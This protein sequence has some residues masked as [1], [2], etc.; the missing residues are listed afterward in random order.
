MTINRVTVFSITLGFFITLVANLASYGQENDLTKEVQVVKPYEPSISDAFKINQMPQ[1]EDTIKL[2][3]SFTYN[4]ALRPVRTEFPVKPIPAARMVA[5]PLNKVYRSYIKFGYGN[6]NS[7]LAEFYLS[8]VRS[9]N[10]SYG[11]AV[12]HHSSFGDIKIDNND[13]V[14]GGFAKTSIMAFGKRMFEKSVLSASGGFRYYSYNFYGVDTMAIPI[15]PQIGFNPDEQY[16]RS[17]FVDISYH[18]THSDST[19]I[20][21]KFNGG[22]KAFADNYGMEQNTFS[23]KAEIDKFFKTE[24]VGG[25]VEFTHHMKNSTLDSANNTIFRF[26]P[27]MGLFGK[28]W[29]V[30]IGVNFAYDANSSGNQSHFFPTGTMSYDIVSH[31]VIPYIEFSGYLEDNNYAKLLSE[32]PWIEPGLDVW[33]TRHK[34]IMMGGV[35]GNFNPRIAYNVNASFS[36]VDSMYFYVNPSSTGT[37][38]ENRFN[39][40]FD[41]IQ[42][43]RFLGELT[44]AATSSINIFL[45]AEFNSYSMDKLKEPWHKPN[46]LGR[47][48]ITYNLQNKILLKSGFYIEGKRYIQ[49]L[50][51]AAQEIDGIIDLNLGVEYRY[52]SRLSAFLDLNNLT[53]HRHHAWYLYPTQHFNMKIGATYSF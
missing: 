8:N 31:Y 49:S 44:V 51:G 35:K 33:N 24:R 47:A 43:K 11:V 53:N 9:K 4:L 22:F 46:Y 27:W 7:P 2:T 12:K 25:T 19:H 20:N 15:V 17:L 37:Y 5:E 28:Q 36:L 16:Q 50:T 52:N 34:F 6:Y 38:L 10:W 1:V 48:L 45:Q 41:N 3:P 32:N 40:V 39:V 14:D 21:H 42:H 13:K 26:S 18:S 30:K 23:L 29:R